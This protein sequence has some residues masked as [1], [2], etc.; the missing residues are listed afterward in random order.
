MID[1]EGIIITNGRICQKSWYQHPRLVI[2]ILFHKCVTPKSSRY[3]FPFII[4]GW[5]QAIL[6]YLECDK[7]VNL[8]K[9][10]GVWCNFYWNVQIIRTFHKTITNFMLFHDHYRCD[11]CVVNVTTTLLQLLLNLFFIDC[12]YCLK[13]VDWSV[14]DHEACCWAILQKVGLKIAFFGSTYLCISTFLCTMNIRLIDPF[15]LSRRVCLLMNY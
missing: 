11:C 5:P 4:K 7:D 10:F 8:V 3:P 1:N 13:Q 6:Q 9:Y 2:D 14:V 12:N 15:T